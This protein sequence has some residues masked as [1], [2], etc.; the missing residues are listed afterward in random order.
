MMNYDLAYQEYKIAIEQHLD[1]F[2]QE[3]V[4]Q[5][6]LYE[7]MRYSLLGGGKRIRPILTLEFCRLCAGSWTQAL[8]FAAAV[9]MVQTYSLIH[10]D[11]PC[12]DDD[13]YRRNR[14][15]NHKVFGE[16]TAVLA[17][18]ALLTAAFDVMAHA[19]AP[20]GVISS[21]IGVLAQAIG[22]KGMV[23]GQMLDM[24]GETKKLEKNEIYTLQRLKT[25][26]LISASAQLGV[27][28]GGGSREQLEAAKRY[29]EALGLAFQ[30]EDD[31]LD[32]IG[33]SS[34]MGKATGMDAN[35]NTFVR[36]Y[37][38]DRCRELIKE[39]T[40]LSISAL[41]IFSDA[42]FL[43]ELALRLSQREY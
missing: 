34:K 20:S 25:G 3:D 31:L 40:N 2:F 15:T 41:H 29:S 27:I 24:E 28:V 6:Q 7:A 32:V 36:L 16:A 14:L 18:D 1:H 39:Q 17:G 38:I 12:M 43:K 42:V 26:A 22:E 9:E 37:G 5:R 11:L 35:K 4:P 10:D 23:G 33:D 21:A 19:D 8:D 30:M 13:D